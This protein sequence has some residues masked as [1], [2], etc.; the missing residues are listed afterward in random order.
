MVQEL[1]A[2]IHGR[3]SL[4][5]Q[6]HPDVDVRF[7]GFPFHGGATFAAPD[8]FHDVG[9]AHRPHLQPPGAQI[10]GQLQIR[11][12]VPDDPGTGQVIRTVQV[13]AE[14]SGARLAAGRTV[15]GEVPVDEDV[16]K[17][18]AFSLQG[19]QK[20]VL[21]RPEGA[22]GKGRRAQAVLVGGH[23]QLVAQA[24]EGLQAGDGAGYEFHFFQGID[25]LVGGLT[26]ERA[27]TVNEDG[28]FHNLQGK[29][30]V[31][32]FLQECRW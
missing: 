23:Y 15:G 21:G 22:F 18:H 1:E 32:R 30:G 11:L 20:Q 8:G 12:P 2:R 17:H 13:L 9:P 6:V 16:V 24:H 14:H 25:L 5:I 31:G 29:E 19:I 4:A 3:R 27:V 10:G 28:F 26:Q 7:G